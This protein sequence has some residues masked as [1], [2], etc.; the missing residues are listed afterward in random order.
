MQNKKKVFLFAC[1]KGKKEV[2]ALLLEEKAK[3]DFN[4]TD[5]V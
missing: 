2:V 3:L 1:E 4:V 5:E